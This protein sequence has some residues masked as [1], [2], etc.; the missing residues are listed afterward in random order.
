MSFYSPS[1]CIG[2]IKGAQTGTLNRQ[3]EEYSRKISG[4]QVPR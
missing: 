3:P 1:C 4:I 2:L